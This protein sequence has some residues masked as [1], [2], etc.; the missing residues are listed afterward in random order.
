MQASCQPSRRLPFS[1]STLKFFLLQPSALTKPP[2]K[3]ILLSRSS[4]PEHRPARSRGGV[5]AEAGEASSHREDCC[6]D[7]SQP[8]SVCQSLCLST[9][10]KE[11][12]VCSASA[13][14]CG[15]GRI[16]SVVRRQCLKGSGLP[17]LSVVCPKPGQRLSCH[18]QRKP[19]APV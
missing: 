18:R 7:V 1:N 10:R 14:P 6:A 15:S 9:F 8:G 4:T 13:D 19:P 16:R 11:V 12:L 5:R 2:S 3:G 17:K